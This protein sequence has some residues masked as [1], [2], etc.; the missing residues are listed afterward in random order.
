MDTVG[1]IALAAVALA[2]LMTLNGCIVRSGTIVDQ[3]TIRVAVGEFVATEQQGL[4]RAPAVTQE[5]AAQTGLA[6]LTELN[7]TINGLVLSDAHFA[8]RLMT[9]SDAAGSPIYASTEP[10]DDWIFVFTAPPQNGFT[11]VRGVVVIDAATG[12][13]SSAQILQ[14]N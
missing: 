5:S 1:R 3:T 12:R 7:G 4:A 2:S 14:S 8:P 13:I 6:K 11:S 10:A 9:L